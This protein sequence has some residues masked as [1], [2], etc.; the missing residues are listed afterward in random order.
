ME[1]KQSVKIGSDK[2]HM[3]SKWDGG[4]LKEQVYECK[5]QQGLEQAGL[6]FSGHCTPR[7]NGGRSQVLRPTCSLVKE[8][9]GP[10][11]FNLTVSFNLNI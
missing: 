6:L 9:L 7:W 2:P 8:G 11:S 5:Y 10:N 1:I 4:M 3:L